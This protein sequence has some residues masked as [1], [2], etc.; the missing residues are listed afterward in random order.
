MAEAIGME[1]ISQTKKKKTIKK[2]EEQTQK[3]KEL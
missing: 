2:N 1:E 3:N